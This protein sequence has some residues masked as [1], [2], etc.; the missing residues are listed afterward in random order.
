MTMVVSVVLR[1]AE[2]LV[3]MAAV[4]TEIVKELEEQY[5]VFLLLVLVLVLVLDWSC[6]RQE[7]GDDKYG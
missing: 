4:G 7:T 2:A 6:R 5:Y 1:V 3:L